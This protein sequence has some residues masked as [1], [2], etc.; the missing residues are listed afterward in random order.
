[1]LGRAAYHDPWVLADVGKTRADVVQKMFDYAKRMK[2]LPL[3]NIARHILGL[4]HGQPHARIWRRMLSDSE[5]LKQQRSGIAPGS[6]RGGGDARLRRSSRQPD[7]RITVSR[8]VASSATSSLAAAR[9]CRR[10]S[11]PC[12]LRGSRSFLTCEV[13]APMKGSSEP[14]S[15]C[16]APTT[17][18][19]SSA[20]ARR[21]SRC[22]SRAARRTRSAAC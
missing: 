20:P 13:S 19:P 17:R 2:A 16:S 9:R 6:A 10:G 12:R 11:S 7:S 22:R 8:G 15:R 21:T 1:M 5:R 4:Y 18:A 14:N 3:R